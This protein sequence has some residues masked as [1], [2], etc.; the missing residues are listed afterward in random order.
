MGKK[1]GA[2]EGS[3]YQTSDGRWRGA[4]TVGYK[5]NSKGGIARLRRVLSVAREP[6]SPNR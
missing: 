4:I 2:G 1:R 5:R 6:M 3:I